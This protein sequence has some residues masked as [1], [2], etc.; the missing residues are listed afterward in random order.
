M[1]DSSPPPAAGFIRLATSS[2]VRYCAILGLDALCT[3]AGLYLALLLRFEG[4]VPDEQTA[5]FFYAAPFLVGIRVSL[6]AFTRLHRWS[7]RWAGLS[8]A[9]RLAFTTL[10][11]TA[12]FVA[13]LF[14]NQKGHLP[15]TVVALEF[16]F[17]TTFLGAFRFLP[18]VVSGWYFEQRVSHQEDAKR[19]IIVGAGSAGDLL[20]RDLLR[21]DG[22]GYRVVGFVDDDPKKLRASIGGKPV[23]G[24]LVQLPELVA[25]HRVTKVLMAIPRLSAEKIQT[26]LKLC[27]HLKVTFKII[28]ASFAYLDE[29]VTAAMLHDLSPEDLLPRDAVAFDSTEIRAMVAGRRILVTGA[30]GSIGSE[31]ARQVAAHAPTELVMVDMNENELYLLTR[32]LQHEHPQL[33]VV[34]LIADI[35]EAVRMMRIGEQYKPHFVF[36][37][38]AHKHVPLMEDA[39]EEAVKNNVFGTA[40]VARM[41]HACGAQRFVFISTDKAVRPTSVMGATKR[42]AEMVIR[43]IARHSQTAFTAVR[44]GNVL[45]SAGSVVPLFREQIERGGPVTVT[46]ANC[47]RYFMTI[48]EAVG[49]VLLAGLGGYGELCILDMGK[50]IR[51]A[52]LAAHMI[53]MAG[54]VPGT[55]I[56]IVFTGLRPGEKLTE[57]LF[58]EDEERSHVVRNKIYV[59]TSP[60]P[61]VDFPE[62]LE[63]LRRMGELGDRHNVRSALRKIVPTYS[64]GERADPI[65]G[66]TIVEKLAT[67][68]P[69]RTKTVPALG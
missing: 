14:F 34:A 50:P 17:T 4:L 31:I 42:V 55:D 66:D 3:V 30:A 63:F 21:S 36:H 56:Q 37:A 9:M 59:A 12:C 45:G 44:F 25:K 16:F 28:P 38:A 29:R 68:T 20:L 5:N 65:S 26:I 49:L 33:R 18:R 39:P 46:D 32:R 62:H 27:A 1:L 24:S 22:H 48:A 8:E 41:A 60:G 57:S 47:T 61:S 53:T 13:V 19:T 15:R 69:I 58:T 43:D 40:N 10:L 54:L 35:R 23:L 52:D 2:G 51:I 67:I 11:G 64:S 6:I 7:F